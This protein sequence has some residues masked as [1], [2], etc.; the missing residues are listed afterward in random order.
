[1][2]IAKSSETAIMELYFGKDVTDMPSMKS[3]LVTFLLCLFLG[4]FG[5]HRFYAGKAG[6][7][8]IWLVTLGFFGIGWIVDL[9]MIIFGSFTDKGGNF[10]SEW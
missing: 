10:I 6:T 1:M 5:M 4:E 2:S 9:V 3:R 8:L 7:G